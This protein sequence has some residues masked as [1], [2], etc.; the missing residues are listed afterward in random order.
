MLVSLIMGCKPKTQSVQAPPLSDSPPQAQT[1]SQTSSP[2][3]DTAQSGAGPVWDKVEINPAGE[4]FLNRTQVSPDELST[5]CVRVK[6][7]G[8]GIVL[9]TGDQPVN[10]AQF[11]IIRA[12]VKTGVH[13]KRAVNRNELD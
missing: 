11:P 7:A 9:Y 8:G 1:P 2:S 6:Q 4:I 5:E 13:T 10:T 12:I 3:A